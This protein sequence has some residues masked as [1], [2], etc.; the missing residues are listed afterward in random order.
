MCERVDDV[1]RKMRIDRKRLAFALPDPAVSFD[2]LMNPVRN[3]LLWVFARIAG[4]GELADGV[5]E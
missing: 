1:I 2:R 4:K 3:V 5:Q